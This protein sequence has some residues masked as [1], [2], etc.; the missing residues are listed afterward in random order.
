MFA[1]TIMCLCM[2]FE[3]LSQTKRPRNAC[4]ELHVMDRCVGL[5]YYNAIWPHIMHLGAKK[6]VT[7]AYSIYYTFRNYAT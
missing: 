7:L 5:L 1:L 3:Q 2:F 6:S 4:T